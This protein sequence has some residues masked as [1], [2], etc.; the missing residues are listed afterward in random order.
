MANIKAQ[1]FHSKKKELLG[2]TAVRHQSDRWHGFR[3]LQDPLTVFSPSSTRLRKSSS[4]N[5]TGKKAKPL[6]LRPQK[7]CVMCHQLNKREENL[8]TKKQQQMQRLYPL[9]KYAVQTRASASIKQNK[10]K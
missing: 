1:D 2:S 4:G 8:M 7:T 3:V 6:D 5:C 9:W 10:T